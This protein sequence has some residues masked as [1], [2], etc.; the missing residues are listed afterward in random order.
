MTPSGADRRSWS[1]PDPRSSTTIRLPRSSQAS[2]RRGARGS[3]AR[4]ELLGTRIGSPG[5]TVRKTA[6]V[7]RASSKTVH[8]TQVAP[9]S[10]IISLLS[11]S[12]R[13]R[14]T[15]GVNLTDEGCVSLESMWSRR[16]GSRR[17][18]A[19]FRRVASAV[20]VAGL[21]RG[22]IG[23]RPVA[24]VRP[25]GRPDPGPIRPASPI[26]P[27]P[28]SEGSRARRRGCPR[29]SDVRPT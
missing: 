21:K 16:G 2:K 19:R 1:Q 9:R 27:R 10:S 12:R 14:C 23:S 7:M 17:G 18:E 26:P 28:H 25:D 22:W 4:C 8:A 13:C 20:P 29:S 5:G 11:T 6:R 24:P 3:A 15:S